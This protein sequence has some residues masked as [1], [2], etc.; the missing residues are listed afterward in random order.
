MLASVY[1]SRVYKCFSRLQRLRFIATT[2][3]HMCVFVPRFYRS[4]IEHNFTATKNQFEFGAARFFSLLLSI[5]ATANTTQAKQSDSLLHLILVS[6][7]LMLSV[8]TQQE[9]LVHRA[10]RQREKWRERKRREAHK[11]WALYKYRQAVVRCCHSKM[12]NSNSKG[13]I[14]L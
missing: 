12:Y 13:V 10:E 8:I 9:C 5:S 2:T 6:C 4:H 7:P 11:Q 3:R 14:T 1:G